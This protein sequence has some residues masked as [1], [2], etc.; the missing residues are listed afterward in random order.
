[1]QDKMISPLLQMFVCHI[2]QKLLAVSTCIIHSDILSMKAWVRHGQCF[3]V[4]IQQIW[5]LSRHQSLAPRSEDVF[6]PPTTSSASRVVDWDEY[7]WKHPQRQEENRL[8]D[9]NK[10]IL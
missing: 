6:P 9:D 5:H 10:D 2:V 1:M 4:Q 8:I 7:P 3:C